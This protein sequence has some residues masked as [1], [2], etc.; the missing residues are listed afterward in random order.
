MLKEW[1]EIVVKWSKKRRTLYFCQNIAFNFQLS[2]WRNVGFLLKLKKL[3]KT[4]TIEQKLS[5]WSSL[6]S[7]RFFDTP[8]TPWRYHCFNICFWHFCT[9]APSGHFFFILFKLKA[10]ITCIDLTAIKVT[11]SLFRA[12][13]AE[14]IKLNL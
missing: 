3:S 1:L 14:F 5:K 4:V 8:G 2:S 11:I 6:W 10:D 9:T 7:S 13:M 12:K